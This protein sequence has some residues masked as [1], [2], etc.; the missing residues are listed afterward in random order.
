MTPSRRLA[1]A[2][3]AATGC[4]SPA[5]PPAH[6]APAPAAAVIAEPAAPPPAKAPPAR[7]AASA[8]PR[9]EDLYRCWF[10]SPYA[11]MFR[12]DDAE[13]GE[14]LA[15]M[16]GLVYY[17]GLAPCMGKLADGKRYPVVGD[18][19]P[20]ELFS[21]LGVIVR[22][23]GHFRFFNRALVRWGHE[24]LI[25]DPDAV[26]GDR[27]ARQ[28]YRDQFSRFFRLMAEAYLTLHDS[29]DYGVEQRAYREAVEGGQDGL[30]YLQA[31]YAGWLPDLE[32]PADG[33][34]MTVPMAIGFWLRRGIDGTDGELWVGLR[35][36]LELYD[37][38]YYAGLERRFSR[39]R[40]SW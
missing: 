1:L 31:H 13:R 19:R 12:Q 9:V 36:V 32:V 5:P 22:D 21:G 25:P 29:R 30:D 27:T 18:T 23:D 38:D 10:T 26:F 15:G 4:A 24:H 2:A 11:Y 7:R 35:K 40:V 34:A 6:P 14:F 28:R 20:I 3:L 33:T 16:K 37:A 17:G 8:D 39:A